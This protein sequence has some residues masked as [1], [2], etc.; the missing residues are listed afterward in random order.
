MRLKA[1]RGAVVVLLGIMAVALMSISSIAID[2]SRLWTLRNELQTAADAA[3]HAGAIQL[4]PPNNAGLT[5]VDSAARN[6][7]AVNLAM[8]GTVTVDSVLTIAT[9]TSKRFRLECTGVKDP[10]TPGTSDSWVLWGIGA[11]SAQVS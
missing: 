11:S 8:Q 9:L 3:A 4:L 1:R 10:Y 6:Y 2:F 7:A 5:W